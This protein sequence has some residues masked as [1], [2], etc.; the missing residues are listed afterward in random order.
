MVDTIYRNLRQPGGAFVDLSIACGR[1]VAIEPAGRAAPAR[2]QFVDGDG[3]LVLPALVESHV[4]LDKTLW[5][6]PWRSH[7]AGPSL[8]DLIANER[9]VLR[10][11]KAPIAKRA[12]ALL[13]NCV[14]Q[15]SLHIRSHIDVNPEIGLGHVEALLALR[16][17]YRD[18]VDM[19]F[20]VFPQ[21]GML[22]QPGTVELMERALE[23]GVEIVGGLDPAGIDNDPMRHLETIFNLAGKHGRGVDIHLHD[24]G[25]LGVWQIERIAD[26]TRDRGLAGKVMISHAFCLGMVPTARMEALGRRLADLRISLMTTAPADLS[27]PPVAFLKKL[28]VNI[29]CGSDGIRDAWSPFGNGDMLER[30]MLL[31]F[32]FDWRKDEE[33]ASAFDS[34]TTAGAR[35]LGLTGYGVAPGHAAN[36]I[37]LPA[38]NLSDALARRP[39]QR[40]V[41]SRGKVIARD[42]R[43][44]EPRQG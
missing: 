39:Q 7:T 14:A 35:A 1:I 26:F 10:E 20:V 42:A 16:E 25:E 6:L 15:G 40:T 24:G 22:I 13:E 12:G 18:V 37:L 5:G 28:G 2:A 21:T 33:L 32:R 19:Q 31:A 29:C 36:F 38:E 23:M 43:F 8:E 44:L 17:A 41:V 9:R 30:A 34:A 11:V 27:V 3:Q 4:H